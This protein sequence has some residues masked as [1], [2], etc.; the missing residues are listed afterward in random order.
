MELT[1]LD[2]P[3]LKDPPHHPIDHPALQSSRSVFH[4]I[5]DSGSLLLQ[6]PYENFSTSVER[7]LKEAARDPKRN[8]FV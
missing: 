6:H 1:A 5:R 7:F 8:N 3:L 4:I 2:F